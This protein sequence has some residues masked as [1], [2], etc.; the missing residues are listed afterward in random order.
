MNMRFVAV[1]ILFFSIGCFA[2]YKEWLISAW[3]SRDFLS[4]EIT[5]LDIT[6]MDTVVETGHLAV[7]RPDFLYETGSEYILYAAGT[8]YAYTSGSDVGMK[9]PL[10]EFVY[11]D[12]SALIENLRENFKLGFIPDGEGVAVVG[13]DGTGNVEN[14]RAFLDSLF[15]P[16]RIGWVDIFGNEVILLFSDISLENPGDVFSV[17]DTLEFIVE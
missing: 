4:A 8:L 6:P 12:I 14:F 1:T 13:S 3:E 17:P 10:E 2:G 7:R 11:A 9:S 15:L 16:H 5:R